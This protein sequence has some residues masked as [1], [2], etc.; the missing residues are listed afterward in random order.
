MSGEG[1][2]PAT[3]GNARLGYRPEIDALRAIAVIAVIINHSTKTLLPSGYLG[4][5]IFF[6]ISGYVITASLF[7]VKALIYDP[8]SLAFT[9]GASADFCQPCWC[10]P[11][12][13]VWRSASWTL[14]LSKPWLREWRLCLASQISIC[15][16]SLPITFPLS[17][18]SISLRI[19][20]LLG[21]RSNFTSSSHSCSGLAALLVSRRVVNQSHSESPC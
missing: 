8:S 11:Q 21:L 18:I 2:H 4:V 5:D 1:S 10:M 9:H 3:G 14:S 16:L 12:Q 15:C 6:V 7:C 19:L 13:R 20:G 17:Q